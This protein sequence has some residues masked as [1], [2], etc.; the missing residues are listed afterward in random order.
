[1]CV[2]DDAHLIAR[3]CDAGKHGRSAPAPGI[4][5]SPHLLCVLIVLKN[6]GLG[7]VRAEYRDDELTP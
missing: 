5:E 1:M 7:G 2:L 4:V 3:Q 6:L